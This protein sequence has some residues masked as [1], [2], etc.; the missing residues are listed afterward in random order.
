[1]TA[2]A[3]T[4]RRPLILEGVPTETGDELEVV[5]PYDGRLVATVASADWPTCDAA[6]EAATR[7]RKAIAAIPP[8]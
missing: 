8:F 1:M 2:I 4:T 5:F 6:L 7:A 3:E